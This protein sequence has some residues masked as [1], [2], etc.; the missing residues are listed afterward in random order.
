MKWPWLREED[1]GH[2]W[3]KKA[4]GH[5]GIPTSNRRGRK[6]GQKGG[7]GYT[8]KQ[9]KTKSFDGYGASLP[10]RKGKSN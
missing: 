6:K 9:E 2:L 8:A 7:A 5:G 10:W 4:K 1:P 3:E